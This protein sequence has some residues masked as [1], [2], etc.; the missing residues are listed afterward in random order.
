MMVSLPIRIPNTVITELAIQL[1]D[2][3]ER[4]NIVQ[5]QRVFILII[6]LEGRGGGGL[7]PEKLTASSREAA[8]IIVL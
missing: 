1:C 6:Q 7:T 3:D 4:R 2:H 8:I 5:L